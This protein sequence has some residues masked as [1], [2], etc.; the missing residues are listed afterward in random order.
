MRKFFLPFASILMSASPAMAAGGHALP[1]YPSPPFEGTAFSWISNSMI[2]VWV[3][4]IIIIVFCRAATS[5]LA[6][7][8]SGFQNFAE[9]LIESLYNFFGNIL[10]EHLVHLNPHCQLPRTVSWRRNVYLHR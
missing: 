10:G 4:A 5:K 2:M 8:P 9:W 1:L 6:L 3:A 7:I